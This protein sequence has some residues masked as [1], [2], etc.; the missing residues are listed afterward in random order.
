LP[1]GAE[2]QG[3][4][5]ILL[6]INFVDSGQHHDEDFDAKIFGFD[7]PPKTHAALTAVVARVDYE[8]QTF[9]RGRGSQEPTTLL[10]AAI[11]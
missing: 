8:Q 11:R 1:G 4:Y 3:S 5:R 6:N 2:A 7:L 9:A 10:I